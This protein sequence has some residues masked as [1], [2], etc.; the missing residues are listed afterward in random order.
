[1]PY[2]EKRKFFKEVFD[3]MKPKITK[4]AGLMID[5]SLVPVK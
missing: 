5:K 4:I 3:D 2:N 1:M